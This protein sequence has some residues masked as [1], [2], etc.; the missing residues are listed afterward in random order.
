MRSMRLQIAI[1]ILLSFICRFAAAQPRSELF[2]SNLELQ[3]RH[4]MLAG[5]VLPDSHEVGTPWG[6]TA[7]GSSVRPGLHSPSRASLAAYPLRFYGLEQ[8]EL[9]PLDRTVLS[10]DEG[11]QMGLFVGALGATT[12]LFDDSDAWYVVG[13]VTAIGT[14]LR[15]RRNLKDPA[16]RIRYRWQE[17]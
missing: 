17:E 5:I 15:L 9:S 16:Y 13:A 12:G 1:F 4:R 8:F 10:L 14:L 2:P 3:F 6:L 11:L 7:T